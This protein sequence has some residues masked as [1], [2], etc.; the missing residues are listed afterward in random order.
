[1]P[2]SALKVCVGGWVVVL[3]VN[4]MISFAAV[5]D[6]VANAVAD[7]VANAVADDVAE[8][9]RMA[10]RM[11]GRTAGWLAGGIKIRLT[12]PSLF[13]TGPEIGKI[14]IIVF[15]GETFFLYKF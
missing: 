3:K 15:K 12:Q 8:A 2:G 11:A 10:G 7:A 5:A 14:N 9:E 13:G 6:A 4:L 1:V